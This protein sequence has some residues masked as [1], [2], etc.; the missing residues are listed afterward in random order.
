MKRV[1]KTLIEMRA[2]R[3]GKKEKTWEREDDKE[4][5]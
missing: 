4:S 2:Q 3:K 5:D 1:D